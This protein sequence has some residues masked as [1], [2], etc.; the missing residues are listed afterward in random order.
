MNKHEERMY[1]FNSLNFFEGELR[2]ALDQ[3][4]DIERRIK[5]YTGEI[6]RLNALLAADEEK[7]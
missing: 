7:E 6:K 5:S 3:Q 2:K 1:R 4:T